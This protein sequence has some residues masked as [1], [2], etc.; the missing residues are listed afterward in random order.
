MNF[1]NKG[2]LGFATG[3]IGAVVAPFVVS[4]ELL[5]PRYRHADRKEALYY[6]L[7]LLLIMGASLV[8]GVLFGLIGAPVLLTVI[9]T[10]FGIFGI[11]GIVAGVHSD[12]LG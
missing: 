12:F 10:Y 7:A 6:V 2:L 3:L 11:L 5:T 4:W 8:S 1:L 9:A